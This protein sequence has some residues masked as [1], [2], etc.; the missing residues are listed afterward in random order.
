MPWVLISLLECTCTPSRLVFLVVSLVLN[1][2]FT[3]DLVLWVECL[4]PPHPPLINE[5]PPH[6]V[7]VFGNGAFE[8]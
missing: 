3:P 1:L 6:Y 7:M 2:L 5:I 4:G 8:R